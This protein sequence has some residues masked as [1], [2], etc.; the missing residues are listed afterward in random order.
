MN[1]VTTRVGLAVVISVG[2]LTGCAGIFG[3]D[4]DGD[5]PTKEATFAGET[6]TL[7]DLYTQYKGIAESGNHE[8]IIYLVGEGLTV[9]KENGKVKFTGQGEIVSIGAYFG[10]SSPS[11]GTLTYD[12]TSKAVGTFEFCQ[13]FNNYDAS[14]ME[15]DRSYFANSGSL[16][17]IVSGSDYTITG[18][19]PILDSGANESQGNAVINYEGT[20]TAAFDT[21]S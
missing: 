4:D 11:S 18:T 7:P 10:S 17:L 15:S 20:V 13:F 6:Y 8:I 16:E 21:S 3:G 2:L 9:S 19:V 12:S 14:A 5:E 1:S